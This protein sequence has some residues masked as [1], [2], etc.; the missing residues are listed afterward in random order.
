[1]FLSIALSCAGDDA[2]INDAPSTVTHDTGPDDVDGPIIQH[3]GVDSPQYVGDDI[4]IEA[5][6]LDAEGSVL[7][8]QLLYRRQTSPDF[9]TA[10]MIAAPDLGEDMYEGKIPDDK[11][12]SAGMHYYFFAVD[13]SNND[14]VYPTTAPDEYFKFDLTE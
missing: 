14:A 1:M 5:R 12:G 13:A 2:P 3:D 10:G 11:L 6:I 8:A 9:E 4:W 7:L